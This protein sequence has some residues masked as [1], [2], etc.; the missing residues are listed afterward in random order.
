M[1]GERGYQA[2][3]PLCVSASN[4]CDATFIDS[5]HEFPTARGPPPPL[6]RGICRRADTAIELTATPARHDAGP[7]GGRRASPAT[8]E[9][10]G[11]RNSTCKSVRS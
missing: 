5:A 1:M 11:E 3:D 2:L 10:P 6:E 7:G 4:G 8:T 9:S